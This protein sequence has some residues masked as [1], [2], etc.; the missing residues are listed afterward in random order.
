MSSHGADTH[1]VLSRQEAAASGLSRFY[2]G[3][4]CENGHMAQRY[5]TNG[6]CVK[7]N[8]ERARIRERERG[9]EDPSYRMYRNTLRRTGMALKGRAS[10]SLALACDHDR[11]REHVSAR[12]SEGMTWDRYR[13]WEVDH[14]KPLS[15]A[16]SDRE[17]LDL[18]HYTNLQP[19]W[20]RENRMKGGA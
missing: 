20:R 8:A 19:L 6:Q 5:V 15:A 11:L 14:I 2:T 12:F 17:L 4:K 1:V 18:C 7:C 3:R 10:P 16:R 13:Q 9:Q